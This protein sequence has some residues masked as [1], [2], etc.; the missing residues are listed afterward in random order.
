MRVDDI[1]VGEAEALEREVQAFD[2]VFAGEADVIERVR[3]VG[4]VIET[5]VDL[6]ELVLLFTK[7]WC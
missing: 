7:L 3:G 4:R 5:E 1:D 6:W 2:D